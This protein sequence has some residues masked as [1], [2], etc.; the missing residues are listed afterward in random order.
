MGEIISRSIETL[1]G[2]YQLAILRKAILGVTYSIIIIT[3]IAILLLRDTIASP[4]S[5]QLCVSKEYFVMTEI[6]SIFRFPEIPLV[7]IPLHYLHIL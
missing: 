6:Y 1:S 3:T 4:H 2:I 7:I 5:Y